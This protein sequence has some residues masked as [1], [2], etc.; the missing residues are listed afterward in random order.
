[1]FLDS[2]NNSQSS[3]IKVQKDLASAKVLLYIISPNVTLFWLCVSCLL[4]CP[5]CIMSVYLVQERIKQ[6][7]EE[8]MTK[9]KTV[10]KL[11]RL[12]FQISFHLSLSTSEGKWKKP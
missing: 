9:S 4:S 11:R 2:L 8:L 5:A 12:V 10:K 3:G 6:L 7:Q 1:M